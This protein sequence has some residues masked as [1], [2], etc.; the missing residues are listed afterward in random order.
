VVSVSVTESLCKDFVSDFAVDTDSIEAVS[1]PTRES[2]PASQSLES[3]SRAGSFVRLT[4][5]AVTGDVSLVEDF[6]SLMPFRPSF[7]FARLRFLELIA[8]FDS[9]IGGLPA[10]P[11]ALGSIVSPPSLSS[12]LSASSC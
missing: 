8:Q 2:D 9:T 6:L 7:S 4:G 3:R 12:A 10:F 5:V 1:L 11:G